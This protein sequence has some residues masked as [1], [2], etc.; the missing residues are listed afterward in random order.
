MTYLTATDKEALRW[1]ARKADEWLGSVTGD[2][3]AES[4]HHRNMERVRIALGKVG[5]Q[6][7]P[8]RGEAHH[9]RRA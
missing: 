2:A 1:A 3:A 5:V 6:L 8:G 9:G 4:D 7:E